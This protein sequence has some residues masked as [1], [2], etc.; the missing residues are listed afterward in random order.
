M[1]PLVEDM[2]PTGE[3][4][5]PLHHQ[6]QGQACHPKWSHGLKYRSKKPE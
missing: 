4:N 5:T 3:D 2:L 1:H 6:A